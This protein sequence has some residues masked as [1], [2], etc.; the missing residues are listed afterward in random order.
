M[1]IKVNGIT[2]I[3]NNRIAYVMG[4]DSINT[5]LSAINI[6]QGITPGTSALLQFPTAL[7]T[8]AEVTLQ[9]KQGSAFEITKFMVISNGTDVYLEEYGKIGVATN[10]VIDAVV[11]TGVVTIRGTSTSTPAVFKGHLTLIKV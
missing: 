7:Y 5:T 2:V 1:A 8:S 10:V 11:V 4:V 3:D 6:D 9:I